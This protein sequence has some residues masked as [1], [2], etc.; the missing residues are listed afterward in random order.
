MKYETVDLTIDGQGKKQSREQ[1]IAKITTLFQGGLVH[2]QVARDAILR[3][4]RGEDVREIETVRLV[5]GEMRTGIPTSA[6]IRK[7]RE[8][9]EAEVARG[10][11]LKPRTRPS[12]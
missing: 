10:Q 9:Y 5:V 7:E 12:L 6:E 3:I 4:T 11:G 1:R 2:Q 8:E